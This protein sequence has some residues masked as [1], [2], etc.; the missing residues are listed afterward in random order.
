VERKLLRSIENMFMGKDLLPS[1]TQI[2]ETNLSAI[3]QT[4][5]SQ[6]NADHNVLPWIPRTWTLRTSHPVLIKLQSGSGQLNRRRIIVSS[7]ISGVS[8]YID[9]FLSLCGM[10]SGE[11]D[12]NGASEELVNIKTG[13]GS[14]SKINPM[15]I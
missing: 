8:K 7:I 6:R 13:C 10:A 4:V 14:Y 1:N 2:T 15:T 3:T 9:S 11:K 12:E 5:P